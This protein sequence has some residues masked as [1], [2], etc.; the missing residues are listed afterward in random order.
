[1]KERNLVWVILTMIRLYIY[2]KHEM[3]LNNDPFEKIKEGTKTIELRLYD[4]KRQLLKIK[5]LILF[6]NRENDEELLT[7]IVN[8]HR[9]P[10]FKELYKHFDK[11]SMGYNEAED[12]RSEDMEEYYSKEEQENYGVVGIEIKKVK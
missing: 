5:D 10:S 7:E 9:Y 11:I 1:M 4:E 8:L 3:R 12:A 2:M 6:R